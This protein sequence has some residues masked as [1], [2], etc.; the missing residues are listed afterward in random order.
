MINHEVYA[1]V[2]EVCG[3]IGTAHLTS[4]RFP[5]DFQAKRLVMSVGVNVIAKNV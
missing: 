2:F 3:S 4:L 1:D 5:S